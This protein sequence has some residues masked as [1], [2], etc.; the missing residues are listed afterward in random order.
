M[1]R[2]TVYGIAISGLLVCHVSFAQQVVRPS[3]AGRSAVYAPH[4][5]VATS[6]PLATGAGVEVLRSGGNAVDAAIAAAAVLNVVEPMMTGIGGDAFVI[7]WS[8]DEK[9]L[10]GLNASGRSGSLMTLNELIG[11][12]HDAM[13]RNGAETITVPGAL[14]GWAALLDRYGT[15]NLAEVLEP[16]IRIADEGF[17]VS[18]KVAWWWDLLV[19]TLKEDEGFRS[20]FLK[21]GERAPRE[22]E[23]FANPDFAT[24]LR[25]ISREG[26]GVL[27][28]GE[29]GRRIV[30]RVS[31]LGGFLTLDDLKKH[32]PM[33]V[34][35][36]S[37]PFRGYR[38]WELPPNGQ[39]IAALEMLR[40]LEPYDLARMGHNST[41]YLHHLIEAKKLAYADLARFVADP[42]H[43]DAP[44][45]HLLSDEFIDERRSHLDPKKA[46]DRPEP[47]PEFTSSDTTYLTVADSNGNMV[48]LINSI[49]SPFGSGVVVPGTGFALQNR[50]VGFTLEP[51]HPNTVAPGK[52]PFHTIIPAF[53][54]K[55]TGGGHQPWM[56]FGVIGGSMQPQGHVQVLLN[57]LAFE[58]GLQEAIDAPRLRHLNGLE[59]GLEPPIPEEVRKELTALGHEIVEI[60]GGYPIFFG[61]AQAIVKLDRGWVA[62]SEP[63]LDGAAM[64]H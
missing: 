59:I 25:K 45:G 7:L 12:G 23:W 42:D 38:L 1:R 40:I 18:P 47:G 33:W 36:V 30:E 64:G 35:P 32:R 52:R 57:L 55:E 28:G 54:T 15:R 3:M 5:A 60:S 31:E 11:R 6:H 29:L 17:P 13:P 43:L 8:A 24:T 14:S 39:G 4:G 44:P 34:E 56:S 41:A 19:E 48:S 61:G 26:A 49:A 20:T 58:M 63:R 50:G 27:Y 62:G 10:I 2:A 51:D 37:V 53:V 21:A 9:R 16:A 22:G 46:A